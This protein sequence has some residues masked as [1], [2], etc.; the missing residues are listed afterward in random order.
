ME[1]SYRDLSNEDKIF[2]SNTYLKNRELDTDGKPIKLMEDIQKE[3]SDKY[4]VTT[5]TIR[6]WA[7]KLGLNLMAQSVESPLKVLVYDIETSRIKANVWWTGKQYVSHAQ[8]TEEPK[9]ITV[10]YKWL[11][12]DNV[13]H[14]TWDEN[15]S[16]EDLMKSFLDV[17]NSA[18]MVIGQNNDK[19]DNRWVNARAAK[20]GLTVNT[21][22]KSFDIMKQ[23]KKLFRI[24]SY[25]MDYI[26][27]FLG[28]THKQSHEG[29][30]MW[31]MIQEGTVE[32][33]KEYLK[34][35]VEYNVGD[36]IST[37]EMYLRLRKYMGHKIHLGVM[38]GKP[39][40]TCPNCGGDNIKLY[41]TTVTPAG[42]IQ[43]V[44]VC[45]DDEV[46]FKISNTIY[47][48][49]LEEKETNKEL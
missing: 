33:Q 9:I 47:M 12:Q 39:K 31:K 2:I 40:Y 45:L 27:K 19:F 5:R 11:G 24:P 34:K 22:I 7:K 43:R 35:M 30:I 10:A 42:V 41:K 6:N 17:Y 16:D 18:D 46:Q 21:H 1:T 4:S 3:L 29:I 20:Y 38:R 26:T 8:L 25:S 44:M 14:L 37:E 15:H 49:Y 32:E 23:A 48:K 36:I 28:V 13:Y